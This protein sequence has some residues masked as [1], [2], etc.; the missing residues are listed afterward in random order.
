ME[1]AFV[2]NSSLDGTTLLVLNIFSVENKQTNK[3]ILISGKVFKDQP[4]RSYNFGTEKL[5]VS[6]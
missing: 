1:F 4:M 5:L 2:M 6:T 3:K